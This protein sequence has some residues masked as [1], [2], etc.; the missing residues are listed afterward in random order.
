MTPKSLLR[1][2]RAVSALQDLTSGSFREVLDDDS[3][4]ASPKRVLLCSGKIY[5]DLV[6]RREAS[7]GI[8][9]AILRLEQLY[10]FPR[11][12]LSR[13][14][15][16]YSE[17]DEWVWVQDEPQNMGSWNFVRFRLEGLLQREIGYV[18]RA[19]SASTATGYHSMHLEQQAVI[20]DTA[21]G[22][23]E[24]KISALQ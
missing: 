2:P 15:S 8:D 17:A 18:G 22:L 12:L 20:V 11:D 13:M 3:A 16:R 24:R 10:P 9:V 19:A 5:Y 7:E 23:K 4:P 6:A 21:L 14:F 1:N